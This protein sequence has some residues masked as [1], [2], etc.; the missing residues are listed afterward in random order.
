MRHVIEVI[1]MLAIFVVYPL[2]MQVAARRH[3]YLHL[4]MATFLSILIGLG[5][6]VGTV[7]AWE[8]L[9]TRRQRVI[10]APPLAQEQVNP[11][12]QEQPTPS[13]RLPATQQPA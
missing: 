2:C 10:P 9:R 6:L 12:L 7:A 11:F 5:P 4:A 8:L 3:G 1:A 13:D